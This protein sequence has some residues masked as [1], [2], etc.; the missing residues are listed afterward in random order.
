[1]SEPTSAREK[2]SAEERAAIDQMFDAW[3]TLRRLGWQH[4]IYCPKDGSWFWSIEPGSTGVHDTQYSGEW[5]KGIWWVAEACDLWPAR[6][7]LWKPK[8][9]TDD[10]C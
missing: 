8:G 1:M 7:C 6:P 10:G 5:P 4:A 9:K 3:E 2:V